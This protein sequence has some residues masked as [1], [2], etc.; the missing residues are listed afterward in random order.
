MQESDL[1][2][3]HQ[4]VVWSVF[5]LGLLLGAL[6]NRTNF[7]TMGAVADIV[8]MGDWTRMRMW[9]AAIGVAIIGTQLLAASGLVD[10][11]RSIYTTP[12]LI[13]LSLAFG[14]LLFGF[15]MVLASGCGSKTLVRIGGGSLKSLIVFLVM[16]LT[17]YMT[18]R[19]V[20]GVVRV[21]AFDSVRINLPGGQDLPRLLAGDSAEQ[22]T[23]LQL[24]LG[25]AIGG[26]LLV[27]AFMGREFRR[28]ENAAG[29]IGVGLIIVAG[30]Y[31]S[32]HLGF[33]EEHPN[34][35]E[36]AF[37]GTTSNRPESFSF[38]SPVAYTL[39]LLMLW[40]DASRRVSFGIAAVLGMIAGSFLYA[41]A[42][43]RFRWEGLHGAE[44]TAN[45]M[46]GG[47]LMGVGGVTALGCT[48]GQ[49]LSGL[50]TLAIGSVIAFAF[51]V[52]GAW[53]A[54]KYQGWRIE[55]MV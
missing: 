24:V 31:V 18:L 22:L 50:S 1:A 52:L 38:V 7:C 12:D 8:N 39:D 44:D 34:T 37:I 17:A 14:G 29:G 6:M 46:V 55:R 23:R 47:A 25:L 45:H 3:I 21:S 41:L 42:S 43:R 32:G 20:F 49:G 5:A 28:F 51:I 9:L 13:W 30:W 10:V 36:T 53:L 33:V 16:G 4:T 40:S 2:A 19:G 35:L 48:I 27:L 26:A 15:G 54:M 11:S